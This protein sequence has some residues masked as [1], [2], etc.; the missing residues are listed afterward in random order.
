MLVRGVWAH[1]CEIHG[2]VLVAVWGAGGGS[3]FDSWDAGG[4]QFWGIGAVGSSEWLE[5]PLRPRS[6]AQSLICSTLS[7]VYAGVIYFLMG[8]AFK[9]FGSPNGQVGLRGVI[10]ITIYRQFHISEDGLVQDI[11]IIKH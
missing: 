5:S 1:F 6:R 3:N 7:G 10:V 11:I 9:G 4:V 2:W 8:T